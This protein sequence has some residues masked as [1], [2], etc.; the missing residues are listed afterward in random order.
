MATKEDHIAPWK[1]V[2]PTA[3]LLSKNVK[4]VLGGSGHIAGV[5]NPP[6]REKY[7]YRVG[8]GNPPDA[9]DWFKRAKEKPGSWWPDWVRWLRRYSGGKVPARQPGSDE[10]RSLEPA[11]G[12]YVK[13]MIRPDKRSLL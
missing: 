6:T 8:T 4:F 2:Y 10:Y 1:S 11:P 9:D 3:N 7:G 12:S 5:I 13:K